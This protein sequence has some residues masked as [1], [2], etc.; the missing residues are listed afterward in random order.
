MFD[1][2][3]SKLGFGNDE[4]SYG[5]RGYDARYEQDFGD[6]YDYGDFGDYDDADAGSDVGDPYAGYDSYA[7]VTTRPS[8]STSTPRLVSIDDV[9]ASTSLSE[10]LAR[11]AQPTRRATAPS[12]SYSLNRMTVDANAPDEPVGLGSVAESSSQERSESLDS[13]FNPTTASPSAGTSSSRYA[14]GAQRYSP[15]AY[16]ASEE[17]PATG[18]SSTA[19]DPYDAYAGAGSR[20]H[21]PT[22]SL[23]VL[24]PMSY[25]EVERIAK[26]LKAGD[27]VV[28]ALGKTP[29]T[30]SKRILDFSF[31]VAS[32][33]D[34][35]VDCVADKVFVITRGSALSDEERAS[36]RGKG[37]L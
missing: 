34:A 20:K 30:L 4:D 8:Y 36:L 27:V 28:L 31:G 21:E 9:R 23:T 12:T 16:P 10:G 26:V 14:S 33:L 29:A 32:A 7:T 37:V 15:A 19:F 6:D 13:L 22:R 1:G 24:R 5:E 25:S 17:G 3:K 2:I 11:D 35:S 18:S